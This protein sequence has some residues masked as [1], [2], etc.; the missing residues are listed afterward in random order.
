MP[1][2][3][4]KRQQQKAESTR[5]ILKSAP[6]NSLKKKKNLI[7]SKRKTTESRCITILI[8]VSSKGEKMKNLYL[9]CLKGAR[10]AVQP[11]GT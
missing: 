5:Q 8:H 7:K 2:Q 9:G 10:E 11:N 4:Q 6:S 3:K 1:Q